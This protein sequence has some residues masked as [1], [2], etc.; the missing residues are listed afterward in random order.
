MSLE[1]RNVVH[2]II[3]IEHQNHQEGLSIHNLLA[4]PLFFILGQDLKLFISNRLPG[5]VGAAG[6]GTTLWEALAWNEKKE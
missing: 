6:L 1:N 3:F 5:N 4:R 2:A